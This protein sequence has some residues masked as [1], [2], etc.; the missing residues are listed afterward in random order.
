LILNLNDLV[1]GPEIERRV[2]VYK[3]DGV[4]G[5]SRGRGRMG[6]RVQ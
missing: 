3:V 6:G 4:G 2:R 1:K 5:I